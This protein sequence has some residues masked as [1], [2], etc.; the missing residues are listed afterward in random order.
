M[1]RK[2][3]VWAALVVALL[4]CAFSF[5]VALHIS[6]PSAGGYTNEMKFAGQN[7][8]ND[9]GA[10]I[11]DRIGDHENSPYFYRLDIYNLEPSDTLSILPHFKTM[12][13]T[14]WW[15]CGQSTVL[16]VLEYYGM[17]GN[18]DEASLAALRRDHEAQHVGTC[19]DQMI[20]MLEGVGGF[21]LVTTYD[22]ANRLDEVNMA[23]FREQIAAGYPVLFCWNDWGGHWEVAIGY[24][25]MGTEHK[26]DDVLIIADPFDT[27]DH[28]QDGYGVLSAERFFSNYLLCNFFPEDHQ[29]DKCFVVVK[30]IHTNQ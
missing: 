18:W 17:R 6:A 26:G 23:F 24:D 10:D 27:T 9:E 30:P 16:M 21:E 12:N 14:S 1:K 11:W 22:Y 25:T 13:Q 4:L 20:D 3:P 15:S 7:S 2:V 8:L 28:N 5:A 19:L 29:G